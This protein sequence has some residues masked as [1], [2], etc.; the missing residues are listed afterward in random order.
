[1]RFLLDE[2]LPTA[3]CVLVA[4]LGH[5]A[6]HVKTEGWLSVDDA[7][8]WSIAGDLGA[9]VMSKDN[10]FLIL[11]RR[12]G[13]AS[14]LLHLNIGNI[15]NRALYDVLRQTWPRLIEGLER[16]DAIVEVRP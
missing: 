9:T 2:H 7:D 15:S 5:D 13:R 6:L 16:G 1:M 10:D 8:L 11:A 14:G 3:L 12:D 4:E